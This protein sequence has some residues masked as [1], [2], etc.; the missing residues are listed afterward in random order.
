[1]ILSP[2]ELM[3]LYHCLMTLEVTQL[4]PD[5]RL[6]GKLLMILTSTVIVV[7]EFHVHTL[8]FHCQLVCSFKPSCRSWPS[9]HQGCKKKKVWVI[10]N[11]KLV[12]SESVRET[13]ECQQSVPLC[14][15]YKC[16][17]VK[18]FTLHRDNSIFSLYFFE[19]SEYQKM[20]QLEVDV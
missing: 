6:S 17:A 8:L 3:T 10:A 4:S 11:S 12:K 16:T 18:L 15:Q 20:F 7:S 9:V 14:C 5:S 13:K 1:M 19:Y 2:A